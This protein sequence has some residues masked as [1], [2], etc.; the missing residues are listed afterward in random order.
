MI[1]FYKK[2]R[3]GIN[4]LILG[5]LTT[6]V[7]Y[8]VY[9]LVFI[10][11]RRGF[12]LQEDVH[13]GAYLTTYLTAQILQ[14]I[15]AVMTAF[16]TNR[17]WVFTD[18][19]KSKGTFLPQLGKFALSR[20]FTFGVDLVLTYVLVLL[21][22]LF[23][24]EK[25]LAISISSH[26]IIINSELIAKIIASVIVIVLNYIL[27]K[28]FVFKKKKAVARENDRLPEKSAQ[29]NPETPDEKSPEETEPSSDAVSSSDRP[30]DGDAESEES[31]ANRP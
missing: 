11:A 25:S 16:L 7:G 6:I 31:G 9:E 10:V 1:Q 29:D 15:A 17:A 4:Y 28:V 20:L 30:K 13:S 14:W 27:S 18:A 19:D 26:E 12:G 22:N 21:L 8:V 2:H 3:E 5:V 23:I 24:S